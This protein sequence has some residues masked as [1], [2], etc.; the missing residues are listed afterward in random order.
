LINQLPEDNK[1]KSLIN[2]DNK[3][4]NRNDYDIKIPNDKCVSWYNDL[5]IND[6][7]VVNHCDNYKGNLCNKCAKNHKENNQIIIYQK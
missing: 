2:T 1:D 7:G 5:P 4:E 3:K 6:N